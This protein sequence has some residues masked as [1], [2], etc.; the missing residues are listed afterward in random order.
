M[1]KNLDYIPGRMAVSNDFK[2]LMAADCSA[3]D[4]DSIITVCK[5]TSNRFIGKIPLWHNDKNA[6]I[7]TNKAIKKKKKQNKLNIY[8][9]EKK[10]KKEI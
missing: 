10:K 5:N 7:K 1:E 3:T 2:H 8:K 4:D 6:K 9:L